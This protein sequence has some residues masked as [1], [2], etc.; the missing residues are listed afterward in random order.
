MIISAIFRMKLVN[1][2][3]VCIPRTG[4]SHA[5]GLVF[6]AGFGFQRQYIDL[7]NEQNDKWYKHD[8]ILQ[9]VRRSKPFECHSRHV[10]GAVPW[11][12]TDGN[13]LDN[14]VKPTTGLDYDHSPVDLQCYESRAFVNWLSSILQLYAISASTLRYEQTALKLKAEPPKD[15]TPVKPPERPSSSVEHSNSRFESIRF[16]SLCESI[17]IDLF[18]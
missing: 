17:R 12:K 1:F 11:K 6:G 4:M 7:T 2:V 18:L 10:S 8:T 3:H 14:V 9:K 5:C 16:D 15:C 13:H